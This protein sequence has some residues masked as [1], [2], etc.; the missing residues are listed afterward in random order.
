[1]ILVAA[2]K[3]FI[4]FLINTLSPI[5][6]VQHRSSLTNTRAIRAPPEKDSTKNWVEIHRLKDIGKVKF[7]LFMKLW[8]RL[9][10]DYVYS[11]LD[12]SSRENYSLRSLSNSFVKPSQS[13]TKTFKNAFFPLCLNESNYLKV[14]IRII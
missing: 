1:M 10:P 8:K 13:K 7:S 6:E 14:E 3:N 11:Y 2:K 5:E 4:F 9:L 12:F